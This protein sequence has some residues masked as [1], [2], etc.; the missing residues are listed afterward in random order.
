MKKYLV[1]LFVVALLIALPVSMASANN[2]PHGN[3]TPT[4]DACAGCHRAHTASGPNILIA[5]STQALCLTCHGNGATGADTDVEGGLYDN[6]DAVA[7]APAEGVVN[8]PLNG[9]GFVNAWDQVDTAFEAVTSVHL[10]DE[11]VTLVWDLNDTTGAISTTV[12]NTALGCASCHDPHGSS[13]Y[14]IIKTSVNGNPV[15]VGDYD[16]AAKNYTDEAWEANAAGS[17]PI[18]NLCAAC[19]VN[20]HQTAA[21]SGDAAPWAHRIDV[22]W[23]G[24]GGTAADIG[25]GAADNPETGAGLTLPLANDVGGAVPDDILVCTTCHFAHGGAAQQGLWSEGATQPDVP[26]GAGN[27][28]ALLRIDNRGVCQVCHDK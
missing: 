16:V 2:G 6:L 23:N 28:S 3:Y 14:R 21:G 5:S 8:A 13:N 15:T 17:E 7:E 22:S 19:H 12:L 9:G 1:L 26:G 20:Y 11:T 27:S 25:F 24:D 4:T 10:T 18:S